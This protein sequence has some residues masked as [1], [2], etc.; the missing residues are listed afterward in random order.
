MEVKLALEVLKI[1][2]VAPST[3]SPLKKQTTKQ[4]KLF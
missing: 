1:H 3:L 2:P 4:T